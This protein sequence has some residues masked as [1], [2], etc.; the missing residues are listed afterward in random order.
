MASTEARL[1]RPLTA[2]Q[3]GAVRG[4]T[5]SGRG[6]EVVLGVAGAGK[7][8]ALAAVADAFGAAGYEVLGSATSGQAARA[9]A[10]EAGMA[11]SRTL[12]SSCGASTTA[13]WPCPLAR[14]SSWTRQ[15]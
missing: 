12:A 1:G 11:H 3:A 14:W 7:T 6:A 4:L 8:T 10:T 5:T 15:G 2:G 9:L 13:A